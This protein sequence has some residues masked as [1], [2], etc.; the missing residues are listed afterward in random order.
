MAVYRP[1]DPLNWL[2]IGLSQQGTDAE[3]RT[4]YNLPDMGLDP[5]Y[6]A[7]LTQY[8]FGRT[9]ANAD[10]DLRRKRAR[11]SYDQALRDLEQQGLVSASNTDTSLLGRGMFSSG[12]RLVRQD[13]LR[14]SLTEGRTRA[15]TALS[16]EFGAIDSDLQRALGQLDT[17]RER[18]IVA[19]QARISAAQRQGAVESGAYTGS[20]TATPAAPPRPRPAAPPTPAATA[21]TPDPQTTYDSLRPPTSR[22]RPSTPATQPRPRTYPTVTRY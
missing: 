9:T 14:R 16:G 4:I 2:G 1:D 21:T 3:G 13:D 7:Y 8:D 5:E 6:I 11:D 12:E 19:S 10:A 18:Q 17:E 15:D 22:P 20:G